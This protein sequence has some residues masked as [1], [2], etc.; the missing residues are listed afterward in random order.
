MVN[1]YKTVIAALGVSVVALAACGGAEPTV[2]FATQ[3]KPILENNCVGCH[4]A[5]GQGYEVSGLALDNYAALMAGTRFGK[6]VLPGNPRDSVLNML[7]E[8]R[9]DPSISMPHGNQRKLFKEEVETLRLWVKQG[10][11]DN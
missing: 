10:A 6:V 8:G 2:S 1:L 4:V 7:V 9:A 5:G 11:N 3:V